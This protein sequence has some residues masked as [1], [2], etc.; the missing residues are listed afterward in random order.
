M[1]AKATGARWTDAKVTKRKSRKISAH[2]Y[3]WFKKPITAKELDVDAYGMTPQ[4]KRKY[5]SYHLTSEKGKKQSEDDIKKRRRNIEIKYWVSNPL[6]AAEDELIG[7]LQGT[8][9]NKPI[10]GFRFPLLDTPAIVACFLADHGNI[11]WRAGLTIIANDSDGLGEPVKVSH[12]LGKDSYV[13]TTVPYRTA[14]A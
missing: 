9:N 12:L 4:V 6:E 5:D 10:T 1:S 13:V 7:R 8:G 2:L 11:A 14:Y 3:D